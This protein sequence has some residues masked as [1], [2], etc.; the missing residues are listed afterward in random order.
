LAIGDFSNANGS[1]AKKQPNSV[2]GLEQADRV[3]LT[4]FTN[5]VL[6]STIGNEPNDGDH[7][8]NCDRYPGTNKG[9]HNSRSIKYPGYFALYVGAKSISQ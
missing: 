1:A 7:H 2:A 9:Q 4:F 6:D 5:S 8:V 3:S